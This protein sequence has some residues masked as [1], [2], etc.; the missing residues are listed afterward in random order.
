MARTSDIDR[1]GNAAKARFGDAVDQVAGVANDAADAVRERSS[2]LVDEAQ[3]YYE[4]FDGGAAID[5]LRGV[6]SEYP[7][8]ALLAAAGAGYLLARWLHE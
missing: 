8:C 3:A 5:R 7:V 1:M 2:R 4:E 6:I